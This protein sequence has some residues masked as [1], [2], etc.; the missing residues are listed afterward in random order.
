LLVGEVDEFENQVLWRMEQVYFP[1]TSSWGTANVIRSTDFQ[2]EDVNEALEKMVNK[3]F[4]ERD[5]VPLP[6]EALVQIARKWAE[7]NG[8]DLP[9]DTKLTTAIKQQMN[10][11]NDNELGG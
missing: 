7:K 10:I 6:V 4:G 3:A 1:E 8:I 2:P 11:V 5:T 9:D